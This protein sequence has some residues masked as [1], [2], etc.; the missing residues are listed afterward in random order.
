MNLYDATKEVHHGAQETPFGKR[1]SEGSLSRQEWLDWMNA[2]AIIH[3]VLD[4]TMPP[5]AKRLHTLSQDIWA[6]LPLQPR[7]L[8]V[9]RQVVEKLARTENT[10]FI[11]GLVYVLTG[12]NYRGGA[13]IRKTLEPLGF[14]CRH[15]RFERED[16]IRLEEWLRE[17][18]EMEQLAQGAQ[19][20]FEFMTAIMTEIDEL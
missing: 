1:M 9:P 11:G 8:V 5:C 17:L 14:P 15:L 3:S 20:A 18:R 2:N 19:E 10:A 6:M 13:V 12:A 4:P 7:T 16:A